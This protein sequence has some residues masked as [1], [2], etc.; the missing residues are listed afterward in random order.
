MAKQTRFYLL[1]STLT[2]MIT[3]KESH[4]YVNIGYTAGEV[5]TTRPYCMSPGDYS[6]GDA[7]CQICVPIDVSDRNQWLKDEKPCVDNVCSSYAGNPDFRNESHYA[8]G[9]RGGYYVCSAYDGW[10]YTA[11]DPNLQPCTS[12]NCQSSA[13]T[14]L[15]TGYETRTY[16]YCST[17]TNCA[18]ET[19]YRCA[20]NYYGSTT[21][22]TSGCSKCDSSPDNTAYE[23]NNKY[24]ST[25][26]KEPGRTMGG[27]TS[28]KTSCYIPPLGGSYSYMD[29]TG[30]YEFNGNCY[31]S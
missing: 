26:S 30:V 14:T 20:Q 25:G 17:T 24:V 3:V 27:G 21:N 7:P 9:D 18:S 29:S 12:S 22:G 5:L 28:S 2:L 8:K 10:T 6:D 13:W 16:R 4:A 11:T 1:I 31:W 23:E 15:R 19:Q